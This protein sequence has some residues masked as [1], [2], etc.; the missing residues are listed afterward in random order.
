LLCDVNHAGHPGTSVKAFTVRNRLDQGQGGIGVYASLF[1][2]TGTTRFV[3]AGLASRLTTSM[4]SFG[5]LLALSEHGRG[6]A[7]AGGAV[8]A[9]TLTNGLT[10]P[11]LGRLYDR[12]GQH[13]TLVRIAPAFGVLMTLLM[14]AIGMNAPIWLVVALAAAAGAPMPVVGPLVRARWT[15]LFGDSPLLR[16]AYGFESATIEVVYIVGPV[17]VGAL[18]TGVGRMAG[19]A[20]V[21]VCGVGGTLALAVQRGTEPEPAGTAAKRTTS[22]LRLPALRV[23]YSSRFCVGGVFGSVPVATVAFATAHGHRGQSG[24]LLGL[25][26]VTSLVGGLV[27]GAVEARASLPRR[28]LV[29]VLLFAVGGLPLLAVR[30][31]VSVALALALAGIAMAPATVSAMEVMQ[32]VVPSTMLTETISWDGTVLAL[33]MTAGTMASGAVVGQ[34]PSDLAYVVPVGWGLLSLLLVAAG[35]GTIGSACV[36]A[37]EPGLAFVAGE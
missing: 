11:A 12:R 21:V 20:A 27:Y 10:M 6:Y 37:E 19:L 9:L 15:A 3:I 5:L 30:G 36:E 7:W 1:G 4:V 16:A 31:I 18:A 23:L 32:R 25:W 8:A 22:S 17:L 29:T 24:L 13:W 35:R 2:P 28:L 14:V 26:G 33:G 34:V